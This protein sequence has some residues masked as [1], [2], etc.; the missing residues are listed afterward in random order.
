MY[1]EVG[2]H[3][4]LVVLPVVQ[5]QKLE[6]AWCQL[7]KKMAEQPVVVIVLKRLNKV[8]E[9]VPQVFH[10]KQIL[11]HSLLYLR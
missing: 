6:F 9:R 8:V 2:C 1:G 11:L 10:N 3:G 5:E 4:Q 7:M